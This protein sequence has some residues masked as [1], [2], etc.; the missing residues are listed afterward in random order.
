MGYERNGAYNRRMRKIGKLVILFFLTLLI[1]AV[2]KGEIKVHF[3]DVGQ[4]DSILV[5]CDG[6]NLLVDAGPQEAGSKVNAY[7]KNTA[8]VTVLKAVVATHEH[9]DHLFGM[10]DALSGLL[11]ESIYSPKSIPMTWWFE[12]VMPRLPQ[13]GL[14]VIKPNAGD[15]F[16]IG[17]AQVTF[18]N[19]MAQSEIPNNLSLVLRIE[20]RDTSVLLTADLEGD[21]E[22]RLLESGTKLA[23]DVLKVAHHGGNTSTTDGFLKAVNPQI[24]VISVGKG[25]RHGH[26]HK[27]TINKLIKQGISIYRTDEFGTIV[28]TSDG[29]SWTTEVS[30]AR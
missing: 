26:P 8:G 12:Q 17:E 20:Y 19:A 22:I 27:E 7:L 16:R 24:A 10:P 18:L 6:E 1:P 30:K 9:D 15:S 25:N 21:G 2:T 3:I 23:S 5:Q 11:I 4:G 29:K 28:L 14:N 13:S